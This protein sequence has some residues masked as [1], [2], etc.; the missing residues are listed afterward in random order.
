VSR[1]PGFCDRGALFIDLPYDCADA[2]ATA[3]AASSSRSAT[4]RAI[5]ARRSRGVPLLARR[6]PGTRARARL[7]TRRPS[8]ARTDIS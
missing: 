8:T 4:P 3:A 7:L 2:A 5:A 1:R 6:P